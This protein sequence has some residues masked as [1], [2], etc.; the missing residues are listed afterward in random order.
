M[1]KQDQVFELTDLSAR[2]LV[3][4]RP[5][6][7]GGLGHWNHLWNTWSHLT[8]AV[9]SGGA[10]DQS[11]F[12]QQD[13][14]RYRAFIA[15]MHHRAANQARELAEGL[16]LAGVGRVLDVGGGSGAFAMAL[17]RA[18]EGIAATVL[19]LPQII[20]LTREYLAAEG[21]EDRVRSGRGIISRTI[22]DPGSTW[23]SSRP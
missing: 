17:V 12:D 20:P 6:Y 15:A 13:P 4:G 2:H 22:W 21:L 7:M 1:E 5:G 18:G 14:S 10:R 3:E 9:K 19:D 8:Q 23:F 16:D 11:P